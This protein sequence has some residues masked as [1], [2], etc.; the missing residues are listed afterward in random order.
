MRRHRPGWTRWADAPPGDGR[1]V[2]A[3]RGDAL[4]RR[5]TARPLSRAAGNGRDSCSGVEL[6]RRPRLTG[7]PRPFLGVPALC[8]GRGRVP[9]PAAGLPPGG[10]G[11]PLE[12]RAGRQKKPRARSFSPEAKGAFSGG[13]DV[14]GTKLPAA[15]C[16]PPA[17]STTQRAGAS[18]ADCWLSFMTKSIFRHKS[19]LKNGQLFQLSYCRRYFNIKSVEIQAKY[20]YFDMEIRAVLLAFLPLAYFFMPICAFLGPAR[21][22][23]AFFAAQIQPPLFSAVPFYK[24]KY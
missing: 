11:A 23:R 18:P 4:V 15:G 6:L 7:V 5:Q 22:R 20:P 12:E 21:K 3:E 24:T 13:W 8:P 14:S 17:W 2:P 16:V 9:A 10:A 1:T 19:M